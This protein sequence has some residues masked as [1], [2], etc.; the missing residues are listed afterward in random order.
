MND[1]QDSQPPDRPDADDTPAV[2]SGTVRE[3][4]YKEPG[5]REQSPATAATHAELRSVS[6]TTVMM[7]RSGAE[8]I[9]AQRVAMDRSG[10]KSIETKSAQLD[11][12][13]VVALG[14]DNAVL[15]RS[16]AVQVVAEEARLS[17]SS[18]VFVMA[19]RATLED[20]RVLV[21]AGQADGDVHTVL[22]A[23]GAAVMGA[24]AGLVVTL[25]LVLLGARPGKRS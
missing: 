20:S 19:E 4:L 3:T 9:T 14:S 25:L 18:A 21:F 16:S 6:A 2:D 7:D 15:L 24:A 8:Q 1:E 23:R 5:S 10:A 11:H 13:G 12:S 17:R 22:T